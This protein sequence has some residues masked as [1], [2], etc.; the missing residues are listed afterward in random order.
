MLLGIAIIGVVISTLGAIL[1]PIGLRPA[2][3]LTILSFYNHI[4]QNIKQV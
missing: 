4:P 2:G 3:M 1:P